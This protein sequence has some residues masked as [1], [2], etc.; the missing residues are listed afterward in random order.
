MVMV[1][2]A[3]PVPIRT[4]PVVPESRVKVFAPVVVN[5]PAPA[6][7]KP[8]ADVEIVSIDATPVNAPPE[9]TFNP[10]E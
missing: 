1:L 4:E 5:D 7:V 9:L 10:D 3:T 2:A 6:K 8:V